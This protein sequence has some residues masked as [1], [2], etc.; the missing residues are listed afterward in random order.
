MVFVGKSGSDCG[1]QSAIIHATTPCSSNQTQRPATA[2]SRLFII[3]R[4]HRYQILIVWYSFPYTVSLEAD[5]G[6]RDWFAQRNY[7]LL[8]GGQRKTK[9]KPASWSLQQ[10]LLLAQILHIIL[11][12]WLD[13][14]EKIW[15]LLNGTNYFTNQGAELSSFPFYLERFSI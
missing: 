6:G 8:V 5:C 4:C 7:W 9:L 1:V 3:I 13:R 2:T 10:L 15:K 12:L 11:L 14:N